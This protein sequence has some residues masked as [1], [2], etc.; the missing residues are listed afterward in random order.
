MVKYEVFIEQPTLD[1]YRL[2]YSPRE[3]YTCTGLWIGGMFTG[4]S[5]KHYHGMRGFNEFGH[6][7]AQSYYFM[8]LKELWPAGNFAPDLYPELPI[9]QMESYEYSESADEVHFVGENVRLDTRVGS[10]DWYDAKGRWELHAKQLGQAFTFF[11]SE[12]DGIALPMQYRSQIGKAMGK[13]NE[14]PVEGY[15]YFD[16]SYSKPGNIYFNLPLLRKIEKRWSSWLVEYTDGEIDGGVAWKGQGDTG[17]SAGHLLQKGVSTAVSDARVF[18]TYDERGTVWKTRIELGGEVVEL[19]QDTCTSWPMHTF[20][21]VVS[22]SRGKEIAKSWTF[23]EWVPDNVEALTERY[24][25]GEFQ[26]R[27]ELL[28]DVRVENERL[29][30]PEHMP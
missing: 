26:D 10:F 20:G 25:A 17:F 6:G 24:L 29:V 4:A 21:R 27:R 9:G 11:V 19:E 30:F 8:E 12:Q 18:T 14:D 16:V 5:G 23:T 15:T 28:R 3:D 22:T 7:M 2:S 13:I 1:F